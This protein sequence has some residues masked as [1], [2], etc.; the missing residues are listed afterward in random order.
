MKRNIIINTFF[1][2]IWR[3]LQDISNENKNSFNNHFF[4]FASFY[5]ILQKQ[6]GINPLLLAIQTQTAN[7]ILTSLRISLKRLLSIVHIRP[8]IK[9]TLYDCVYEI[10]F[11]YI[12]CCIFSVG[13]CSL[14]S[15]K[16][17]LV[18]LIINLIGHK[19][20]MIVI[21]QTLNEIHVD[22]LL[23]SA[24]R[25]KVQVYHNAQ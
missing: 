4:F 17:G 13:T 9:A 21:C 25:P 22:L 18:I 19:T 3:N 14:K 23:A 20:D 11:R 6:K 1:I 5:I 16:T 15:S 8:S 10:S 2:F 12:V 24:I 7:L